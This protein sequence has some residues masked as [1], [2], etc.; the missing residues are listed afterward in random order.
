MPAIIPRIKIEI[1]A[2]ISGDE[3]LI[4]A[5]KNNRDIHKAT[6][7]LIYG[8][9][10]KDVTNQM[11]ETAKRVNF[12]IVY[13]LTS[14]GL[15]KD[16]NI[17]VDEAGAFIDA[18]F[19]RYPKVYR[20]TLLEHIKRAEKDGFVTT[21]LGRRRYIPEINNK[22]TDDPAVCPAQGNKYSHPGLGQRSDKVGNDRNT[23]PDKI[24]KLDSRMVLQVHDELV[25]DVPEKERDDFAVM[26]KERMENVLELDVP[27]RVTVK[28]GGN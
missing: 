26:V 25:F 21:I 3:N 13:G 24:K 2:D 20:I 14:Y 23:Q 8:L 18:Y 12:G 7:A 11:R 1:L 5:F 4:R 16:L 19:T 10:E 6:A 22:N 27:I 15:S 17:P 28:Q 9:E